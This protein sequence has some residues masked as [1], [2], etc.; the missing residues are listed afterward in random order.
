MLDESAHCDQLTRRHIRAHL[1]RE[2]GVLR[3]PFVAHEYEPIARLGSTMHAPLS[4]T[5]SPIA[6]ARLE[7]QREAPAEAG[8][9]WHLLDVKE[10]AQRLGRS[11]PW[12]RASELVYPT[13]GVHPRVVRSPIVLVQV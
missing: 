3:E 5:S 9:P 6:A 2:V 12:A 8:E 10:V 1:H 7:R 11:A 4:R 13:K